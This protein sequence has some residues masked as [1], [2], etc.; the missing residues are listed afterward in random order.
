[1]VSTEVR[2]HSGTPS[3]VRFCYFSFIG[4]KISE[5]NSGR[6]ENFSSISRVMI[7]AEIFFYYY[8]F[9]LLDAV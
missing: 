3:A 4:K 6:I 9:F 7:C 2:D 1:L 8:R 5:K